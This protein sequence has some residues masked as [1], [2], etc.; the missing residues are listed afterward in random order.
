MQIVFVFITSFNKKIVI[1][2]FFKLS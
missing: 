2:Q 1:T